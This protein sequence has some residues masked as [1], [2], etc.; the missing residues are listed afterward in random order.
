M[1]PTPAVIPA[2]G[3]QTTDRAIKRVDITKVPINLN[4]N[5]DDYHEFS[6]F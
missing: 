6:L 4:L 5:R 2:I 3:A 1:K